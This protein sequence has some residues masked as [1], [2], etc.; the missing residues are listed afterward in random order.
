MS[1]TMKLLNLDQICLI[2]QPPENLIE[3]VVLEYVERM[4][5]HEKLE[6]ILVC[7]D[8]ERYFLKDG[9][10]RVEAA[11]RLKRRKITANVTRGTLEE[12]EAEWQEYLR[13]VKQDLADWNKR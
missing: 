10:H 8:G 1:D 13:A 4:K 6:P 7:F 5:R 12:M 3:P 11:R 9:F 2:F